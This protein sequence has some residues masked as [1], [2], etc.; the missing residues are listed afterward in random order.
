MRGT[1]RTQVARCLGIL[2]AIGAAAASPAGLEAQEPAP[3]RSA[4]EA[5]LQALETDIQTLL[6]NIDAQRERYRLEQAELKAVELAI[7]KHGRQIVE[8]QD[9]QAL[10]QSEIEALEQQESRILARISREQGAL[11]EQIARAYRLQR[12]SRLKLLLN[13]DDPEQVSRLLAYFD[14]YNRARTGEI[15]Q[16]RESIA[17]LLVTRRAILDAVSD[18]DLLIEEAAEAQRSLEIQRQQQATAARVLA[19]SIGSSEQRVA[20]LERNRADLESLLERISEVL[21]DIPE[22][23]GSGERLINLKGRLPWPVTGPVRYGFGQDRNGAAS[24]GWL[25]GA[26][27]GTDILSVG[28]GR[29]AF[30][31][32]LR[33]F[34]LLL[35]VDHGDD[36]LSLYGHADTLLRDVGDWVDRGDRLATAGRS[37]GSEESGLYFELRRGGSP[38]DPANWLG[39]RTASP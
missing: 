10:K 19:D 8:L 34:G 3:D 28:H 16:L 21:A 31:D 36:L 7:Q 39:P 37:G 13:Q 22:D 27:S 4:V 12:Q 33:G 32:W 30:A 23:L 24:R 17:P 15:E 20:E 26:E 29:V 5:Q 14:Y 6:A 1:Y 25:I 38:V 2:L 18:L 35:I 9:E 11:G